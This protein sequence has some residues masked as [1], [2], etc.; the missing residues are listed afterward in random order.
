[1][2]Y[3]LNSMSVLLPEVFTSKPNEN[4]PEQPPTHPRA[5]SEFLYVPTSPKS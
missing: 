1:M 4:N 5:S 2:K 3:N